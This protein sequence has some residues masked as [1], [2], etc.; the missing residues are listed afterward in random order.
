MLAQYGYQSDLSSEGI[1][2]SCFRKS[3][4]ELK[5]KRLFYVDRNHIFN[6]DMRAFSKWPREIANVYDQMKSQFPISTK[7]KFQNEKGKFKNIAL[8]SASTDRQTSVGKR[9]VVACLLED[10][11][12]NLGIVMPSSSGTSTEDMKLLS[13][14]R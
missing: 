13:D 7:T 11:N 6:N 12:I 9:A 2:N 4:T 14:S 10:A 3:P 8:I 5:T 1:V